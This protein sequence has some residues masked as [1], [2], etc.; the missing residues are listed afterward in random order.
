VPWPTEE[1]IRRGALASI[2]V[3]LDQGQDP[4]EFDPE[5][6]AE[7]E[8]ERKRLEEE[9]ERRK[10]EEVELERVRREERMREEVARRESAAAQGVQGRTEEKPKVFMGLDLLDDE[11]ED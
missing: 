1:T 10:E 5:R 8:R 9:A 3:L 6:S 4:A 2:Q 11:D 7:L